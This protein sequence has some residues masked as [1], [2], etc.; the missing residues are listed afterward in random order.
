MEGEQPFRTTHQVARDHITAVLSGDP[1]RMAEDY[2]HNACLERAG[3][4]YEGIKAIQSY[5]E[6]VPSR[7]GEAKIHFD[8][9]IVDGDEATF[10]WRIVG[11]DLKASGTDVLIIKS[12]TITN[13]TVHLNATDF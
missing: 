10:F 5:F 4:V 2:A 9:L 3:D 8:R 11:T 1:N 13:Q 12:G 7:L 6:T